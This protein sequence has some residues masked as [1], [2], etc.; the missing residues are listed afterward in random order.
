MTRI[1]IGGK[2]RRGHTRIGRRTRAN[3]TSIKKRRRG[4]LRIKRRRNTEI[5]LITEDVLK[6]TLIRMVSN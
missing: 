3:S 2:T 6:T 5:S 4:C 1:R